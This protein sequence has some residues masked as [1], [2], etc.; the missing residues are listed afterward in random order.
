MKFKL[1]FL[2]HY[3]TS[4]SGK[5]TKKP[6]L[7]KILISVAF[8]LLI[9][10]ILFIPQEKSILD[11]KLKVG[12]IAKEDIIIKKDITVEDKENT[13]LKRKDAIE[14]IIPVYEYYSENLGKTQNL[15]NEWY[16]LLKQFRIQYIKNRKDLP[17]IKETIEKNFGIEIPEKNLK[18][19]LVSNIFYRIDLNQL[20]EFIGQIEK[21]GI[22]ASKVGAKKS[23]AGTIR[24]ETK[25]HEPELLRV[26]KIHD[27]R[28]VDMLLRA[29]LESQ[30]L[31]VKDVQI[32][33]PI[34]ID[35]IDVN[36]AYSLTL[37]REAEKKAAAQ[38]NPVIIKLKAGKVILRKGDEAK[39]DDLKVMQLIAAEQKIREKKISPYYLIIAIMGFLFIFI[40]RLFR[41]WNS[42]DLNR[43]KLF[44]VTGVTLFL[45]AVI[46]RISIFLFPLILKNISI[47]LNYDI[48]SI[49]FAIPFGFGALII[50]FT[51]NLQSAVIYSFI[52]SITA[53]I[54]CDWNLR[55]VLYVLIGNLVISYGIEYYQRIKRS[56]ILKASIFWLLPVNALF[57]LLFDTTNPNFDLSLLAFNL[58]IG[59]FSA[60]LSPILANFII[61]LW[62]V[63]FNLINDLKLIELNNLNLPIF[64]EMLEKAPGTYH[65]SQMVASLSETA[66]MDL[67]LSPYLITAMALYH[68]IGKIENPQLFTENNSVYSENPHDKLSPQESAKMI[69]AHISDGKELAKKMKIPQIVAS[70]ITQHHGSKLVRFFYDKALEMADVETDEVDEKVFRYPG[71]KPQNIENAIIML[72]DQVEAA[73]KSLASPTDEEIQNVIQKIIDINIEE[74]Q[75]DECDGLTFKSLIIIANGFLKKL[76]SIYHMRVSYPGINFSEN[77]GSDQ[78]NRQEP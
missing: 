53:G 43:D 24:V 64:R 23:I 6:S 36:L 54:I 15:I 62:E 3:A 52:N 68:D 67:N 35:F 44:M 32:V 77:N 56:A 7:I 71:E 55:I 41:L 17:K 50:A 34:F 16:Q 73:S 2:K 8:I 28:E 78:N 63:I 20:F 21:T 11:S 33:A 37:T 26:E 18:Y 40:S 45:S 61:P 51:F 14:N 47:Q 25:N 72:A 60:I 76:S 58:L 38:I 49:Y 22:L 31:S 29:F 10:T 5:N 46:Y 12:D 4:G 48:T 59:C 19:L 74:K 30:N 9:S 57:I 1:H 27:L 66:A 75:F 69:I 65:H 13:Q 39:A 42:A 70:S